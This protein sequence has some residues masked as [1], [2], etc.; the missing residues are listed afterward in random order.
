MEH[1]SNYIPLA[2]KAFE[3]SSIA[4]KKKYDQMRSQGEVSEEDR[5]FP[6]DISIE[7]E[8]VANEILRPWALATFPLVYPYGIRFENSIGRGIYKCRYKDKP[9]L[10]KI[11]TFNQT[12]LTEIFIRE[13]LGNTIGKEMALY[14]IL[15][16]DY[17]PSRLVNDTKYEKGDVCIFFD[18]EDS[19]EFPIDFQ[20]LEMSM[21]MFGVRSMIRAGLDI[22][23]IGDIGIVKSGPL[24][25]RSMLMNFSYGY[26]ATMSGLDYTS[27]I[28]F[29]SDEYDKRMK[30]PV[31][32]DHT[33]TQ[34]FN[35]YIHGMTVIY[36]KMISEDKMR[37]LYECFDKVLSEVSS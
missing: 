8:R 1:L 13:R 28:D 2:R 34:I 9:Y 27:S 3:T 21:I 14:G 4:A 5:I 20:D 37:I 17:K 33:Q 24:G 19:I 6:I 16:V 11:S 29:L 18:V 15:S 23:D 22:P 12:S 30:D 36:D 35:R 7:I 25:Q 31:D 26:F 32:L 10:V